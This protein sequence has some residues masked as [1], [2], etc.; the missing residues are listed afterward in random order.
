MTAAS[1]RVPAEDAGAAVR[2]TARA[3]ELQETLVAEAPVILWSATPDGETEFVSARW[4]ELTGAPPY[5]GWADAIHPDD[6]EELLARWRA[7]IAAAEPY[8]N[9]HRIRMRDGA[10]RRFLC[11]ARPIR[12]AQD[13]IVRWAGS[14]TDIEDLA[15]DADAADAEG[16]MLAELV[17]ARTI[18]LAEAERRGGG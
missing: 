15:R 2:Q 10:W 11:R 7:A 5:E 8:E 1:S 16:A 13:V 14:M 18:D 9:E 3:L 17:E 6:V 12:D 4:T